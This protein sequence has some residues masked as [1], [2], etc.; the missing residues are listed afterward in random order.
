MPVRSPPGATVP[1]LSR[2][3]RGTLALKSIVH[4]LRPESRPEL[5]KIQC[6]FPN[7]NVFHHSHRSLERPDRILYRGCGDEMPNGQ[8]WRRSRR[9]CVETQ[10]CPSVVIGI[11]GPI[12]R[13]IRRDQRYTRDT[14]GVLGVWSVI[15]RSPGP[16]RLVWTFCPFGRPDPRPPLLGRGR[17]TA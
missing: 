12:L 7:S 5:P 8:V 15:G 4:H 2:D 6:D 14:R 16:I 11:F 17:I 1:V 10:S 13:A 9:V 3:S